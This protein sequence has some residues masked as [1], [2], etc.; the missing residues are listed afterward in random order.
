MISTTI[1]DLVMWLTPAGLGDVDS[2][3]L[4]WV[5]SV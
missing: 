4:G 2:K 5:E 1:C 3:C